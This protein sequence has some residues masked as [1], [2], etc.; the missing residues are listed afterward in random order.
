MGSLK[1]ALGAGPH[2]VEAGADDRAPGQL[3]QSE[4]WVRSGNGDPLPSIYLRALLGMF[5]H[6]PPPHHIMEEAAEGKRSQ[7][8]GP[9]CFSK[10]PGFG[11][12]GRRCGSLPGP[13]TQRLCDVRL[14]TP[15]L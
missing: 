7:D 5:H 2:R 14:L 6:T 3:S 12:D 4:G 1:I 11:D 8:S 9:R 15:P 10:M 13:D